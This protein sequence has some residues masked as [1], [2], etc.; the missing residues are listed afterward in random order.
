MRTNI[1]HLRRIQSK[2]MEITIA[3]ICAIIG[4][5]LVTQFRV[6]GALSRKL[7]E[8]S[9]QDLGQI[10]RELNVEI[11]ALHREVTGMRIQSYK[12]RREAADKQAILDEAARNLED[13]RIVAGF[14]RV[15]GN[16]IQI[17]I[18]DK[19]GIL[20]EHD[21]LEIIQELRAAGAEG[22]SINDQRVVARSALE[23][24]EGYIK[25]NGKRIQSPYA[26]KAIGNPEILYQA[27]TLPGGIKDALDSLEGISFRITRESK[28]ILPGLRP[29]KYRYIAPIKGE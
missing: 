18:A 21:I 24:R 14:T 5:L 4:F 22:I 28:V 17:L 19:E 8:L 12:Y 27:V 29:P 25:M 13:L 2:R 15:Q 6:Q 3:I 26:I 11:D 23:K 16:G 1:F 10:I 7:M 9:E 20:N